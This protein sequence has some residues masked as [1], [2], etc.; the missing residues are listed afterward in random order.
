MLRHRSLLGALVFRDFYVAARSW[1][2]VSR[3]C[4]VTAL[5]W[6]PWCSE[7]FTLP[8]A[9]RSLGVQSF[10]R[11][12]A[13]GS[14]GVKSFLRHRSLLGAMVLFSVSGGSEGSSWGPFGALLGPFRSPFGA[15][16]GPSWA[17]LG[18]SWAV[19]GRL[20]GLWASWG[21]LGGLWGPSWG[22]LGALLG[23]FGALLGTTSA[24]L[25][26]SWG[27]FDRLPRS[28]AR[29]SEHVENCQKPI[30]NRWILAFG[31][32]LGVIL[33]LSWGVLGAFWAVLR[34]S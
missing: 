26:R 29:E 17:V 24:V 18:P 13:L 7:T 21:S 22:R 8:L 25:G 12:R 9:L 15:L 32:I 30:G 2:L 16:L 11:H 31:A 27:L 14:L 34:P 33:G 1:A 5:C 4:C 28:K 20:G 3:A 6:E 19:L 23:R 10:L